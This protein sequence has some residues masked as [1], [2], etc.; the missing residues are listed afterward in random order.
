M[1]QRNVKVDMSKKTPYVEGIEIGTLIAFNM[2]NGRVKS[3]KVVR[4]SS[5]HRILKVETN[6]GAEFVVPYDDVIWVKTG[7]RWPKGV[8]NLL[9]GS[10]N[11]ARGTTEDT[12][13]V[14]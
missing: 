7:K 2:P 11:N 9:K 10:T 4:K 12:K 13:P 8:Y 5:S 14:Q 1:S 3:A 6:Y